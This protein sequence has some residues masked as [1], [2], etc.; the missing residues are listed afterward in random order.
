[1][2][3]IEACETSTSLKNPG[4]GCDKMLG[5]SKGLLAGPTDLV[6]PADPSPDF[7]GWIKQ[8]IH[9]APGSRVYI[10]ANFLLPLFNMIVNPSQR[11][12]ETSDYTGEIIDIRGG[13]ENRTYKTTKGGL[14]LAKA[15]A[16]FRNSGLGFMDID[17][18]GLHVL[19]KQSDGTKRFLAALNLGGAGID[20]ASGNTVFKNNFSLSYDPDQYIIGT[21][22]EGGLGILS[23]KN[24]EDVDVVEGEQ[25]ATTTN[26]F[27]GVTTECGGKDVVA[28]LGSGI[29]QVS[30]FIVTKV[31]DGTHPSVTAAAIQSGEVKLTGTFVTGSDYTVELAPT[32][33]LYTN[34]V[35]YYEGQGVATITIP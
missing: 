22:Y 19:A 4:G 29:A 10:I 2:A 25:A 35:F 7:V 14:C 6:I 18:S 11:V 12:T 32:T 28:L 1:M 13:T 31:S 3:H 16:S 9:A 24:L 21:V 23:L 15:W 30:N 20:V 33:T 26:I 5:P 8:Q 17:G 27:V 34:N